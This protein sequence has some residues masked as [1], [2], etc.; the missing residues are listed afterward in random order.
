MPISLFVMNIRLSDKVYIRHIDDETL[1]FSPR[2]GGC[3]V[4]S[5]ARAFVEALS[6]K[7][8]DID[9]IIHSIAAPFGIDYNEIVS[10]AFIIYNE[11]VD[12]GFAICESREDS[13]EDNVVPHAN[14][15]AVET[16]D[17]MPLSS[18]YRRHGN[19]P[20]EFH[21]DLTDACTERCIHCY[22]PHGQNNYLPFNQV[23][24]ALVEFRD[25]Q[26]LSVHLTGGE[27]MLHP[28]FKRIC[29]LCKSLDLN[30]VLFSNMIL[31]DSEMVGFLQEIDPQF[32]NVS[33]Y[34]INPE[35]H[36]AI[37]T[38]V[39]S[40]QRTMD[41]ILACERSGVHIRITTPL[42]RKNRNE[43]G[44]LYQFALQH[45]MHLIP[46]FDIVPKSD[47]DCSNLQCACSQE[48]LRK[49]L[50]DYKDLFD[51]GYGQGRRYGD[52]KVCRLAFWA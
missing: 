6:Y 17:D 34:A 36:D 40:W 11:M 32:V 2:T 39:G 28:E 29:R 50:C 18:F 5:N 22:V 8:Q 48:E 42:L 23:E 26:G 43:F 1:I 49:A 13:Q 37:T 44:Q 24:K 30:I 35:V 27:A 14:T 16:D 33:L 20:I 46:N 21:I 7:F 47:H 45:H 25:M 12:Q 51:E 19:R 38:V 41:A 31:C 4:I 3:S 52:S 10:D 9:S 15:G